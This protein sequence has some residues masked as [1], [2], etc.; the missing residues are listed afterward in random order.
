MNIQQ[1]RLF[2]TW[3]ALILLC[4]PAFAAVRYR[5][6]LIVEGDTSFVVYAPRI[7]AHGD[8]V[9]NA[10]EDSGEGSLVDSVWL[11]T[12]K[13]KLV[14]V[15]NPSDFRAYHVTAMN[16]HGK[17]LGVG[18]HDSEAGEATEPHGFIFDSRSGTFSHFPLARDG[19][20]EFPHKI[21]NRDRVAL[22]SL[23]SITHVVMSGRL[24]SLPTVADIN[25]VDLGLTVE[26]DRAYLM[27]LASGQRVAWM[28]ARNVDPSWKLDDRHWAYGIRG[29]H[30]YRQRL[31]PHSDPGA[32][33]LGPDSYTLRDVNNH[34][35]VVGTFA[36]AGGLQRGFVVHGTRLEDLNLAT[37]GLAGWRIQEAVDVNDRGQIVVI[38]KSGEYGQFTRI[39]R[40]DPKPVR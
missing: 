38:A 35:V 3:L 27:R 2:L 18:Y 5:P 1:P 30:L 32:I 25:N 36:P 14:A 39:L 8:V 15:P 6:T 40:L 23:D 16:D 9:Y 31:A 37:D 13:G 33:Y 24:I 22:G 4:S 26:G 11:Q 28:S 20:P 7:N 21:N 17:L 34:A 19:Y 29:Q 12:A 10:Y